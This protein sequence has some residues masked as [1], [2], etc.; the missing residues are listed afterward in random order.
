MSE[1][2]KMRGQLA[3]LE[4]EHNDLDLKAS[5]DIVVLRDIV[6][7]HAET[8]TDIDVDKALAIM[9]RLHDTIH[10]MRDMGRRIAALRKD[11]GEGR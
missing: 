5:A 2:V 11:L 3:E 4:R 1:R 8:V 6:D 9:Q 7:P 10:R